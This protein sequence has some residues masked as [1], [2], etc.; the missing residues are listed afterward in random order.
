MKIHLLLPLLL[1]MCGIAACSQKIAIKEKQPGKTNQLIGGPCEGCEAI[2]ESPLGFDQLKDSAILPDFEDAGPKISISG[3]I[4]QADGTTP[5]SDIILYVYHTNQKGIYPTNG[6][7]K[8]WAK[9]HGY[10]R[11]WVKTD[12]QGFY[13]FYTLRPG[14][15][16]ERN[17][18]QH[19]HV[20]V[21]EPGKNEYWISEYL[22]DD[23]PLLTPEKRKLY[24]Y[25]GGDG[26]IKLVVQP[27]GIA[28]GKRN[29]TL[30]LNI[31]GYPR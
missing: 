6:N 8:G 10:I 9:R 14:H 27:N 18:M 25:R 31:P 16:P 30:G 11:G 1:N 26:I 23:D 24:E 5:A 21:K 13:Q 7:E 19:I 20:T 4:Y 12:E 17:A 29:I 22:F 28:T 2:Y 15:Y 3:T